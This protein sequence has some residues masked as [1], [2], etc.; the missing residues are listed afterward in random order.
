[1]SAL[2]RDLLDKLA[3]SI[4]SQLPTLQDPSDIGIVSYK[5]EASDPSHRG[6]S[7]LRPRF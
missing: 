4:S 1:M 2:F 7:R 6:G 5:N 3:S